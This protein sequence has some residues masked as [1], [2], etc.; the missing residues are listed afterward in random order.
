MSEKVY[1]IGDTHAKEKFIRNDYEKFIITEKLSNADICFV[2]GD[3]DKAM[4]EELI[5]AK[6]AGIK[7]KTMNEQLINPHIYESLL[8]GKV[9]VAT[10]TA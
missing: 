7:I 2:L 3:T 4:D 1:L 9:K 8:L 10:P 6:E 5:K